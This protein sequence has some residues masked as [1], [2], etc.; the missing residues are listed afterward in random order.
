M[1]S[2]K[3]ME[4]IRL[5]VMSVDLKYL[6]SVS[7]TGLRGPGAS[8]SAISGIHKK[9]PCAI[10]FYDKRFWQ[11]KTKKNLTVMLMSC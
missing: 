2:T 6:V 4:S 11:R 8:N 1:L 3:K 9:I 7:E 5:G 10:T